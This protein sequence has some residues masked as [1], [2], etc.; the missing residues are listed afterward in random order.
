METI[1]LKPRIEK[2]KNI[3]DIVYFESIGEFTKMHFFNGS[4]QIVEENINYIED[5]LPKKKFFKIHDLFI[6]N[7]DHLKLIKV[8]TNKN[9]K[10]HHNLEITIAPNRYNELI[11][12]MK[13]E[14]V[15][16]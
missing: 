8:K 7:L 5:L 2:I 9:A 10:L 11:E 4:K 3:K 16:W 6:I 15:V 14:Y 13:D 1:E 12:F